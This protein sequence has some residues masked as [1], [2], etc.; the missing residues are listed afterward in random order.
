MRKILNFINSNHFNNYESL[1]KI[2]TGKI[3]TDIDNALKLLSLDEIFNISK[4]YIDNLGI[5]FTAM[6]SDERLANASL[7]IAQ[8]ANT[9]VSKSFK[10]DSLASTSTLSMDTRNFII[11]MLYYYTPYGNNFELNRKAT[12]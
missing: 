8:L 12:G 5:H 9:I 6:L 4:D 10:I 1:L 2:F 3:T 7:F 11:R